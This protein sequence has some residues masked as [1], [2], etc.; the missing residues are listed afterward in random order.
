MGTNYYLVN[1]RRPEQ[2]LHIGKSSAGWC[3]ALHVWTDKEDPL[4]LYPRSWNDWVNTICGYSISHT[5]V[6]EYDTEITL[7]GLKEIVTERQGTMDWDKEDWEKLGYQ[8]EEHFHLMNDSER[9]PN[10]LLRSEISRWHCV[11]HGEGT[12]DYIVGEFS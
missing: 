2:K 8:S 12:Y 1:E 11:G 5:I 4:K 3:F 7:S 10:N 6:D 9:G